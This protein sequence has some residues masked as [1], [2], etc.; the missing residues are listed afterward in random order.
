MNTLNLIYEL[1]ITYCILYA[2]YAVCKLAEHLL[3]KIIFTDFF[4]FE[5]NY[6]WVC[7]LCALC[8]MVMQKASW[9]RLV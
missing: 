9:S 4:Q 8:M 2:E 3:L 6:T 1:V 5:V 7:F